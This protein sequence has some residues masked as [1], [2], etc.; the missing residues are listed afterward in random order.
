M[1]KRKSIGEI[2]FIY[3]KQLNITHEDL[4]I[5]AGLSPVTITKIENNQ[6]AISLDEAEKLA[7]AFGVDLDTLFKH[8]QDDGLEN[9]D[10][11]NQSFVNA[12]K[13]YGIIDFDISDIKR[14]DLLIDAL[15]TQKEIYKS[16]N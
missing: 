10:L 6:R 2:I 3:R 5:Q 7:A 11:C 15:Y 4:A 1:I 8:I 12:F 13:R 14:I 16:E 9:N